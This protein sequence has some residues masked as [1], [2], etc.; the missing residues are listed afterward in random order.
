M[1]YLNCNLKHIA[2][3][4]TWDSDLI[5]LPDTLHEGKE[6]ASYCSVNSRGSRLS[7]RKNPRQTRRVAKA[8]DFEGAGR[9]GWMVPEEAEA[10]YSAV[11]DQVAG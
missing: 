1:H 8:A 3:N 4:Q 7:R 10:A 5:Y 2:K 11:P 6:P 9:E